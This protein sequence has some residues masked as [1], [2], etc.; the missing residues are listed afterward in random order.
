MDGGQ[1]MMDGTDGATGEHDEADRTPPE[2]EGKR[3]PEDQSTDSGASGRRRTIRLD[4]IRDEVAKRD[5]G[6]GADM[7]LKELIEAE[8]DPDHP[9]HADAVETGKLLSAELQPMIKKMTESFM[10]KLNL[11]E[12]LVQGMNKQWTD[13]IKPTVNR[14]LVEGWVKVPDRIPLWEPPELD[15]D[16]S[17]SPLVRSAQLGEQTVETLEAIAG[18]L[19]AQNEAAKLAN[20][21]AT[22]VAR[23]T[24]WVAVFTL[25][26][27]VAGI[28]VTIMLAFRPGG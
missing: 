5:R 18:T 7:T 14:G 1:E 17:D 3:E 25:V 28:L 27:T 23:R 9:R 8:K 24:L 15:L 4:D 6:P 13:S 22:K 2:P 10:P 11:G 26:A 16:F 12:S 21:E 20:A 19:L